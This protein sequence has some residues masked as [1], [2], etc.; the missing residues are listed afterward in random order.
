[1]LA[2]LAACSATRPATTARTP[3][4]TSDAS[5]DS[6]SD[7][8]LQCDPEQWCWVHGVPVSNLIP[9]GSTGLFAIG[10]H[11]LVLHWRDDAWQQTAA[12]TTDALV[13]GWVAPNSDL[14]VLTEDGETWIRT[15]EGWRQQTR[16]E[17]L[18]AFVDT[19]G[20]TPLAVSQR[21]VST[22]V[23]R[24]DAGHWEP[25]TRT[26]TP[27]CYGGSYVMKDGDLFGAG[28]VCTDGRVIGARVHRYADDGQWHALGGLI[29][30][31]GPVE[32]SVVDDV[33]R[34]DGGLEWDGHRWMP[35]ELPGYPQQTT[36]GM[37]T[38]GDGDGY[39]AVPQATG[40]RHIEHAAGA[41]WCRGNGQIWREASPGDWRPTVSS[42]FDA[43]G[44]PSAWGR[45]PPALWAGAGSIAAWGSDADTVYR[46][47]DEERRRLQ[48][49]TPRGWATVEEAG[50][51]AVDGWGEHVWAITERGLLHGEGEALEPVLLPPAHAGRPLQRLRA[52]GPGE[53][54][55]QS[56][57]VLLRN[58]GAWSPMFEADEGWGITDFAVLGSEVWVSLTE[59]GKKAARSRLMHFDGTRWDKLEGDAGDPSMLFV[60]AGQVWRWSHRRVE[61]LT[62][63]PLEFDVPSRS[64]G[65]RLWIAPETIWMLGAGRAAWRP[66]A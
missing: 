15:V 1:M 52:P 25:A 63:E 66:T 41:R 9:D 17:R 58:D 5:S 6:S 21:G 28:L 33:F 22:A 16:T 10:E 11:G 42:Q 65:Q 39:Y 32:L 61:R 35:R 48:R 38:A 46:I 49:W 8:R 3:V 60:G 51:S 44:S 57:D 2:A 4:E 18:F 27:Y 47:H 23:W 13:A 43:P 53:V 31:K 36:V 45:I 29:D 30:A 64:F 55:V 26:E 59:Q 14:W 24:W 7:T 40:C 56:G 54:W 62:G 34:V 37:T 20:E 50:V 12:P 19:A